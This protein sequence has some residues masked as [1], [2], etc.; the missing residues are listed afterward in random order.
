[1]K[2]RILASV[3]ALAVVAMPACGEEEVGQFATALAEVPFV[4]RTEAEINHWFSGRT[5]IDDEAQYGGAATNGDPRVMLIDTAPLTQVGGKTYPGTLCVTQTNLLSGQSHKYAALVGIEV[6]DNPSLFAIG[7]IET[8]TTSCD[9]DP[10]A[11]NVT[12]PWTPAVLES[13]FRAALADW[14]QQDIIGTLK[15]STNTEGLATA[16][17]P[18]KAATKFGAL[19]NCRTTTPPTIAFLAA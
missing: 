4:D 10:M 5:I 6:L 7:N 11:V 17:S 18:R 15:S 13:T 3:I 8:S 1:M 12:H 19:Y 14:L 16:A 2:L 9:G